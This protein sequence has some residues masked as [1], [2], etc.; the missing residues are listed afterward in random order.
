M[1]YVIQTNDEQGI[2]GMQIKKWETE[3]KLIIIE[4]SD[5][6]IEIQERLD[7]VA[8]ALMIL[9][10]VGYNSEVMEIYLQ[11]KTNI[12]LSHIRD[13]LRNQEKFLKDIGC[14][15]LQTAK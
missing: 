9:K 10:N 2:I 1:R 4:K 13:I 3:K 5:T 8:K 14:L 15:K 7:K 6:I 11:K 12:G